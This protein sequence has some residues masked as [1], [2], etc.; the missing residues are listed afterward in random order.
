MTIH[1]PAIPNLTRLIGRFFQRLIH[2]RVYLDY[3]SS[4]PLDKRL[5]RHIPTI[6]A[7]YSGANPSA[8]HREGVALRR[9]LSEARTRI[10]TTLGVHADEI[11]FTAS[12]TESDNL[13]LIGC[14]QAHM[15][16]GIAPNRIAVFASAIEHAAVSETCAYLATLGILDG[17]I[18]APDGVIDPKMITV[19]EGVD[20]LII[21]VM[22][23]NNEIGT[24]QPITEIA[25]RVRYLRKQH[26]DVTIVLH[27]DATQAPLYYPLNVAKL[28]VDMLT[29][30]ATKFYTHKGV[31]VLYKR[32]SISLVPILHGGGQ[33]FGLRP[34]T[35]AIEFIHACS[36]A[37]SYAQATRE[38][39]CK[40]ITM[41]QKYFE[42]LVKDQIPQAIITGAKLLRSPHISHIALPEF[43]SE[44]LVL[45]L[46][47]RGIAVSAKSACKS[48]E[49]GE[50][51]TVRMLYGS[52]YGAVR[53]SFGRMT[54]KR[55]LKK[56]VNALRSVIQKYRLENC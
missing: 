43:D 6:D 8:L 4:T 49:V 22:Y 28:G 15:K 2:P 21:S 17:S 19:P 50:S 23:V 48:E 34:G 33:E 5:L 52:N 24:V 31:G 35:E 54:T 1:S 38:E 56:A 9:V 32:R 36:Y 14:A 27:V 42:G 12:A 45:E 37:L 55:E 13:A 29:L 18:P 3:A 7:L 53:F 25:K 44:L 11:I 46:D 40:K 41:L 16:A 10:A 20:V 39:A 47:A 26:P 30:G 51:D